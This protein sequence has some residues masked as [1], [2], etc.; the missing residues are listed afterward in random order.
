MPGREEERPK[1]PAQSPLCL[2]HSLPP[3]QLCLS[4]P[5]FYTTC[6][7]PLCHSD[8]VVCPARESNYHAL[9]SENYCVHGKRNLTTGRIKQK[10]YYSE[11]I[12]ASFKFFKIPS[13]CAFP[14]RDLPP[15]DFFGNS[16]G[17][18]PVVIVLLTETTTLVAAQQ[19]LGFPFGHVQRFHPSFTLSGG[20]SLEFQS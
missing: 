18:C 2:H 5:F 17:T 9:L 15:Q 8:A 1:H 4:F 14:L 3:V 16:T 19:R 7:S 20:K 10:K 6:T 12:L 13:S 11:L